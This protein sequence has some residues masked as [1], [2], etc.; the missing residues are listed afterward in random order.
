MVI[1]ETL[2]EMGAISTTPKMSSLNVKKGDK[3]YYIAADTLSDR[4]SAVFVQA[5]SE[6]L[7]PIENPRYLLVRKNL[8]KIGWQQL[9]YF[10]VPGI[11]GLKMKNVLIF[12]KMWKQRLGSC[13][14]IY[15]RTI[16]GHKILLK[17]QMRA[18][19]N[20]QKQTKKSN[21]WE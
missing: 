9:D 20:F 18:Y 3:E 11:I 16:E 1:L 6:F 8:T 13:N 5:L 4:D 12:K 2:Y 10:S 21:R 15:T 7:N 17:A 14:V 19:S